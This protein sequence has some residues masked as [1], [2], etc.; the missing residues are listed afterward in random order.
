[1]QWLYEDGLIQQ[2]TTEVVIRAAEGRGHA[3]FATKPPQPLP[4]G[5]Y[6]VLISVGEGTPPLGQEPF[7]IGRTPR[8][9][10]LGSKSA[11]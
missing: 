11:G 8:P 5:K 9:D 1:V 7:W 6:A 4:A 2:A 10:E 3:W